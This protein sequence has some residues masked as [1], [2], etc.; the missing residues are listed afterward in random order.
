VHSP[1]AKARILVVDDSQDCRDLTE[2]VLLSE[3]FDDVLTAASGSDALNILEIFRTPDGRSTVD[4]VLLDFSMPT[5]DGVEVCARIR[6]DK[7]CAELP[8][9][10]LTSRD[11]MGS[12]T[13]AFEAGAT[14]YLTKPINRLEIAA[15]VRTALESKNLVR[16]PWFKLAAIISG[17][18]LI[19]T[20]GLSY[21]L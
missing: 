16:I 14:D 12:L 6:K 1:M 3:G 18:W 11:D 15:R 8:I 20:A 5:M 19:A 2:G 13:G 9:I 7:C 10:M 4:V 21:L 17:V